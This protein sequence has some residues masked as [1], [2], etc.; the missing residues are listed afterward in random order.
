MKYEPKKVFILENGN[1]TEITYAQLQQRRIEVEGYNDRKFI[2][3]H[4]VLMEV[5]KE[6]YI[7]FYKAERRWRYVE[8]W[9][10]KK[11]AFLYENYST[12]TFNGEDMLVDKS[13]DAQEILE[14]KELAEELHRAIASLSSSERDLLEEHFIKGISQVELAELYGVNQS[15]ISRKIS[16][17]VKKLKKFL[18]N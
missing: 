10:V 12:P 14:E 13:M 18:E 2:A 6:E 5:T 8:E 16:R 1:Y 11:G 3:L 15:S 7:D 4:G 17:I 9:G